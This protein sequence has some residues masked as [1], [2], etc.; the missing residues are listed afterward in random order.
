MYSSLQEKGM[1][2]Y[3]QARAFEQQGRWGDAIRCYDDALRLDPNSVG[4]L[5]NK[6]IAVWA[7]DP[8][9]ASYQPALEC[10]QKALNVCK[11]Q[12]RQAIQSAITKLNEA[13]QPSRAYE[14]Y[15]N[16]FAIW[17]QHRLSKFSEVLALN[18]QALSL[19]S[20]SSPLYT[21]ITQS[22][23]SIK[24]VKAKHDE[25]QREIQEAQ[26]RAQEQQHK[27]QIK[28]QI[29]ASVNDI[30]IDL[31]FVDKMIEEIQTVDPTYENSS[32]VA[33][34]KTI[35]AEIAAN[36]SGIL[37]NNLDYLD[38][39]TLAAVSNNI[40]N[41]Q[42]N[43][44]NI[45]TD[46]TNKLSELKE[47]YKKN[48]EIL[49]N[50][51]AKSFTSIEDNLT[52]IGFIDPAFAKNNQVKKNAYEQS[53]KLKE[54][55]LPTATLKH[56][57]EIKQEVEVIRTETDN[58]DT[59][60]KNKL[61]GLKA[62]KKTDITAVI[63]DVR[64][65]FISTYALLDEIKYD[66]VSFESTK[67][68]EVSNLEML[69]N[70]NERELSTADL[71]RLVAI[72][73][74][75]ESSKSKMEGLERESKD[76]L[77]QL[78]NLRHKEIEKL[79]QEVTDI[80][81]SLQKKLK[82]IDPSDRTYVQRQQDIK[83]KIL[84]IIPAIKNQ[85]S[86]VNLGT[87]IKFNSDL[88][89]AQ[90]NLT[91]LDEDVSQ[92]LNILKNT[93]IT[94]IKEWI[95][96][97]KNNFLAIDK[98]LNQMKSL[99]FSQNGGRSFYTFSNTIA[100]LITTFNTEIA[101]R[102]AIEVILAKETLL[103]TADL[104]QLI[105]IRM[106]VKIAKEKTDL[107]KENAEIK[108]KA[109]FI[110]EAEYLRDKE[111]FLGAQNSLDLA[112]KTPTKQ[113]PDFSKK[114]TDVKLSIKEASEYKAVKKIESDLAANQDLQ[115]L[116]TKMQKPSSLKDKVKNKTGI[117]LD[118]LNDLLVKNFDKAIKA[119]NR[120]LIL[121]IGL[122][123]SGK[124]TTINY[125]L[126][127]SLKNEITS[128][129][130]THIVPTQPDNSGNFPTIGTT[131]KAET[132]F[133]AVYQMQPEKFAYTDF[134]GFM[135]NRG[136][137]AKIC[138]HIFSQ[139]AINAATRIKEIVVVIECDSLYT[140]RAAGLRNLAVI[141]GELL[142][143]PKQMSQSIRF[144]I[145]KPNGKTLDHIK[146]KISS[147]CDILKNDPN[148]EK[149]LAIV[150]LMNQA[151]QNLN[152]HRITFIDPVDNGQSRDQLMTQFKNTSG[153]IRKEDF[154]SV[155]ADTNSK[156][157]EILTLVNKLK[158]KMQRIISLLSMVNQYKAAIATLEPQITVN[159]AAKN[160][161]ANL[162][163]QVIS[164]ENFIV[165]TDRD[166]NAYQNIF[167]IFEKITTFMGYSSTITSI[168]PTPLPNLAQ[169]SG[170]P[171]GN[172]VPGSNTQTQ[173]PPPSTYSSQQGQGIP[174]NGP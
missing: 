107:L 163:D 83:D 87:L 145:T 132:L 24:A 116:L 41:I 52:E 149:E 74:E 12:E 130:E 168:A 161:L 70:D 127:R 42:T 18:E 8:R 39:N 15:Q 67:R 159:S 51:I 21:T 115:W 147:L 60:V 72:K 137:V 160:L 32:R 124:S 38:I 65:S 81:S 29:N 173:P 135:D 146:N 143:D 118:E 20:Y 164:M 162:K 16:A 63:K 144:V 99:N 76:K 92:K 31:Q 36:Q 100:D 93:K 5:H 80:S 134:P 3:H 61:D 136:E 123:G 1:A 128:T 89:D 7:R 66:D 170:Q 121:F 26:R 112:D 45:K 109:S 96:N 169:Q 104:N 27:N 58:L 56:L 11:P 86:T 98:M 158:N 133:P 14:I 111:E 4:A 165:D 28:A 152:D 151:S 23:A 19:I 88:R 120:E 110:L 69:I 71:P 114:I 82:E 49:I 43:T 34:G 44:K 77:D 97:A 150:E 73:D 167:N 17:G 148:A 156:L 10:L 138:T 91:Q 174:Q 113:D 122:T 53:I 85:Y 172:V 33:G 153:G 62:I 131:A 50:E 40:V 154:K 140:Q 37:I 9:P 57:N 106:E 125:L 117:N 139:I 94:K 141:L 46:V 6:A 30:K 59:D 103:D 22:I 108:L 75:A 102:M 47:S 95:F 101:Q 68:N 78:K 64:N 105:D 166:Y 142:K 54:I 25:E 129:G 13:Y 157:H 84:S 171:L 35:K 48:T 79:L 90:T 126:G 155:P 119:E 55:D 2:L